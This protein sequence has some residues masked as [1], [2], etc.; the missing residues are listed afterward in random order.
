MKRV[1][2]AVIGVVAIVLSGADWRQFRGPNGASVSQDAVPPDSWSDSE[3]VAWKATLPGRG[4]SS[5]IVVKNRVYV[6]CSA[7]ARQ[8]R[9]FVVCFDSGSGKEAWRREFWPT[10]RVF[11]HPSSAVAAPTPA[12]DGERIFAFY[13]SNDLACL[14][15]DGNLLWYRGLALD[16]PKIGND[17]GMSSSPIVAGDTVIVQIESQGDSFAMG[18]DVHTGETRW[19][20]ERQRMWNWTSPSVV[21]LG[22]GK[23]AVLLADSKSL[24]ALDAATGDELW[25]YEM[26]CAN[27]ASPAFQGGRIF[28]P[29]EGLTVLEFGPEATAPSLLWQ[30]NKVNPGPSSPIVTADRVLAMNTAGVLTSADAKTGKIMWQLRVGGSHW[31]TPVLAGDRLFCLNDKGEVHVVKVGPEKGEIVSTVDVKET[32]QGSPAVSD[33]A[34]YIRSDK[35]LWK[36]AK[37]EG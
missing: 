37:R 36:I 24:T 20:V 31:S 33:G 30:S 14:D 7:S 8:E 12:S 11:C 2:F 5:P 16:H 35:H 9:L 1:V 10:G 15:L 32:L 27:I 23:H 19:Q 21:T 18:L 26:S 17:V 29:G 28:V 25:K 22:N 3:N 13:S 34:L 6:T 4:P